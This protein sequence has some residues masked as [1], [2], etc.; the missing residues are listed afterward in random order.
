MIK[1]NG[2][3]LCIF[4]FQHGRLS[5]QW[6]H[7]LRSWRWTHSPA[8]LFHRRRIDLQVTEK[9]FF[10]S[11]DVA[12]L[13]L[14]EF[15]DYNACIHLH[16]HASVTQC[17]PLNAQY[18]AWWHICSGFTWRIMMSDALSKDDWVVSPTLKVSFWWVTS[19]QITSTDSNGGE[20]WIS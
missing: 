1:P 15:M 6:R 18:G 16:F 20:K 10:S 19:S 4:L 13:H 12:Q 5:H 8:T 3:F 17:L 11:R 7:R 9:T 14:S 2:C